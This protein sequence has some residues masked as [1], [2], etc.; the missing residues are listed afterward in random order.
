VDEPFDVV[1][2]LGRY[3]DPALAQ[4]GAVRVAAIGRT[5]LELVLTFDPTSLVAHGPTRLAV[6]VTDADPFPGQR[7]AFTALY[8]PDLP[9]IRRIGVHYLRDGQVVGIAW[10]SFVVVLDPAEIADAPV[11]APEPNPMLDLQPIVGADLPDLVLSVC[12]SDG[13]ATGEFIWTA[14]TRSTDV[15]VPD[16]PRIS[17]L[18]N[19]VQQ[20][21]AGMRDTVAFSTDRYAQYLA[22]VGK[23]TKLGRAMPESVVS[24]LRGIVEDPTRREAPTVLLLTEEVV[25]PWELAVFDPPLD[26]AWGGVSPFL[27]AHA[28]VSRWP[29]TSRRPRPSPRPSVTVRR[30]AVLT[31]DY[32]GVVGVTRLDHAQAEARQVAALFAPPAI[33]VPPSLRDVVGMLRGVPPAD[34]LH[35]AL[36]GRF[37][38]TGSDEGLVLVST[39]TDGSRVRTALV[40]TPD[41]VETGRLDGGPFVFLNACQVASDKRVLGDY[42]GFAST[43]LRI[44]ATGVVAPLWNVDDDVAAT[45]AQDFYAATWSTAGASSVAEAVRAQRARYTEAAA[46][47]HTEGIT[48][49]LIAFQVFGHPRLRLT[50]VDHPVK[51]HDG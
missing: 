21:V 4:T 28:A 20:F 44:G 22:L 50:R 33:S 47:S 41:Q 32:A 27:G 51:E 17:R 3:Q 35:V 37:D 49:T 5:D 43:L 16:G 29:L 31:A 36:H 38:A 48:P 14:Y 26:S 39:D 19:D 13:P 46:E 18:D 9:T 42:A 8:R 1:V 7:V 40:L 11:P 24:M 45:F 2:G 30:A 23:A 25:L 15:A 10:R 34:V 6:A 12:A